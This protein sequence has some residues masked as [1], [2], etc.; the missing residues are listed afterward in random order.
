MLN[1][2]KYLDFR[3][4]ITE[5]EG[6]SNLSYCFKWGLEYLGHQRRQD[7]SGWEFT[8]DSLPVLTDWMQH[9]AQLIK[10]NLL[11]QRS[12]PMVWSEIQV[13]YSW[14]KAELDQEIETLLHQRIESYLLRPGAPKPFICGIH[15]QIEDVV[16]LIKEKLSQ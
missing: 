5:I 8:P 6:I 4:K 13:K 10:N 2:D 3:K 15:Y 1:I 12:D 9:V 7:A 11:A 16:K 14:S